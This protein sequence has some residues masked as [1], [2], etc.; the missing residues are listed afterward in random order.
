VFGA[1]T[2]DEAV[3][4]MMTMVNRYYEEECCMFDV[5]Q[6][7]EEP[8]A[9]E[10]S[11]D[12][13]ETWTP[14]ADLQLCVPLL[15]LGAGGKVQVSAD[16]G[17]TW[18]DAEVVTPEPVPPTDGYDNKCLGARNAAE[19]YRLTWQEVYNAWAGDGQMAFGIIAFTSVLAAMII[20]PPAVA[21]VWSFFLLMWELITQ[22][23]GG[24]WTDAVTERLTC[25]FY[26]NSVEN[27]DGTLNF[28]WTNVLSD[29]V[30]EDIEENLIWA[31]IWYLAQMVGED[32]TARAASTRS[33][34]AYD[35]VDCGCPSECAEADFTLIRGGYGQFDWT[36]NST[37]RTGDNFSGGDWSDGNG[38]TTTAIG[39]G[40]AS[41]GIHTFCDGAPEE[42]LYF[43][44]SSTV[45][46][47]LLIEVRRVSDDAQLGC[48]YLAN[49][50]ASAG[51]N[52]V[53]LPAGATTDDIEIRFG[54]NTSG[55]AGGVII[56]AVQWTAP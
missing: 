47:I 28:N 2:V 15:R 34:P 32:G 51:W 25:I 41:L 49:T 43:R 27:E 50:N 12:G 16:G 31:V 22:A 36:S 38:W 13:G 26:C 6:N 48:T 56:D 18:T 4:R 7:E 33:V 20:F 10:K 23:T 52:S 24:E 1:V 53:L 46:S 14:F 30:A 11:D 39:G 37:C 9:L 42:R 21:V 40:A 3:T 8:C 5:R 54:I 45:N 19:V 55:S 44:F 17:E 29:I 35:C